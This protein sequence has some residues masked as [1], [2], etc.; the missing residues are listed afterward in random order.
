M[1]AFLVV[2][3]TVGGV[4]VSRVLCTRIQRSQL[5]SSDEVV[6]TMSM[7]SSRKNEIRHKTFSFRDVL[8]VVLR[9]E[10]GRGRHG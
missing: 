3:D 4:C 9:E 8:E 7:G 5:N 2:V 6:C 10:E 1:L